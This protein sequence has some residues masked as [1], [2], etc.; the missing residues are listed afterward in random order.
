MA[1]RAFHALICNGIRVNH[2]PCQQ[3]DYIHIHKSYGYFIIYLLIIA[4]FFLDRC[5]TVTP[6]PVPNF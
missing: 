2:T 4:Q 3:H 5:T 1:C 6:A